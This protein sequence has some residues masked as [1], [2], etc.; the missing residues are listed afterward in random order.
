MHAR[1]GTLFGHELFDGL[2]EVD[3]EA[4]QGVDAG[5]LSIGVASRETII[6]DKM[7][8][9][10]AVLL[11]DV[12]AIVF[13]PGPATREREALAGAVAVEGLIDELGAVVAVHAAQGDGPAAADLVDGGGHAVLAFAPERLELDP[14]RGDID[15]AEGEKEEA[16]G[17]AAAMGDEVNC[18]RRP[19]VITKIG[20]S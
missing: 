17:A 13:L 11:L 7:A 18:A 2:E 16:P 8:D 1:A 15:G 9:D 14:A 10:G 12:G 19:I 6:A 3:V 5:E 4:S 20:A